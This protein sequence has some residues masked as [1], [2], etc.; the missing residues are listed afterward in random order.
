[1]DVGTCAWVVETMPVCDGMQVG[2][3]LTGMA[4]GAVP[5]AAGLHADSRN[6][7]GTTMARIF[8]FIVFS[9][10]GVVDV[11]FQT[12]YQYSLVVP[13]YPTWFLFTGP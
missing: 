1:V 5:A 3:G 2:V 7:T 4:V 12:G 10:K 6:R 8:V 9:F 11:D 13:V